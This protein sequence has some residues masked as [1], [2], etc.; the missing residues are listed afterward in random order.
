MLSP[1][2]IPETR[3]ATTL[4]SPSL[5]QKLQPVTKATGR[6]K[7][8]RWLKIAHLEEM[9][10]NILHRVIGTLG[11]EMLLL[12]PSPQAAGVKVCTICPGPVSQGAPQ[13]RMA[14]WSHH[15]AH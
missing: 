7:Q 15:K 6:K 12:T 9:R 3:H 11:S 8:D 13:K 10:E 2:P 5:S 14:S 4:P 1:S